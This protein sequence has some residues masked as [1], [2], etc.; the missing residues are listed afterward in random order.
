MKGFEIDPY[1]KS[2]QEI[3]DLN[4]FEHLD[5]GYNLGVLDKAT[6]YYGTP[7]AMYFDDTWLYEEVEARMHGFYFWPSSRLVVGRGTIVCSE[8]DGS[9]AN[10]RLTANNVSKMIIWAELSPA[11]A[12]K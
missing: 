6:F 9:H 3:D 4:N 12:A 7:Y 2:I 1:S 10:P 11:E 8:E 5:K